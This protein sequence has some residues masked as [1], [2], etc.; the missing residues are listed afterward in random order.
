MAPSAAPTGC[1]LLAGASLRARATRCCSPPDSSFIS[2]SS[3]P[4][5][6]TRSSTSATRLQ[7]LPTVGGFQPGDDAQ[8]RD[9]AAARRAQKA[10]DVALVHAETDVVGEVDISVGFGEVT[11]FK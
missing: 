10:E 11:D 2:R 5:I 9:L 7:H 3:K 4:T 8:Q 1:P 6:P